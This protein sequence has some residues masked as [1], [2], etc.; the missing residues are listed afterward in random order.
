M[1]V[2]VVVVPSQALLAAVQ[3]LL[4]Q[5][6]TCQHYVPLCFQLLEALQV[7]LRRHPLDQLA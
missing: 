2:T 6:M 3:C 7:D 4:A 5:M 1:E